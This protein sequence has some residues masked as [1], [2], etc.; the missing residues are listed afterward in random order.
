[1]ETGGF[2]TWDSFHPGVPTPR[3]HLSEPR[4]LEK[5]GGDGTLGLVMMNGPLGLPITAFFLLLLLSASLARDSDGDGVN[6]EKD[7][8]P[9]DR[10]NDKDNDNIDVHAVWW[11]HK[12]ENVDSF[13]NPQT[14]V[15]SIIAGFDLMSEQFEYIE[16]FEHHG[17]GIIAPPVN[18]PECN[19]CVCWDSIARM[20]SELVMGLARYRSLA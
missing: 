18:I 2:G 12:T 20:Y 7:P 17:G 5:T 4:G 16:P 8:C 3:V 1:M 13:E 6:D 10:E 19:I 15:G 11:G 14:E 9:F